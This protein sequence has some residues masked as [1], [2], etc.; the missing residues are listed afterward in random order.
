MALLG[1]AGTC[2]TRRAGPQW[3]PSERNT[4]TRPGSADVG[5]T[6]RHVKRARILTEHEIRHLTRVHAWIG[7]LLAS[8]GVVPAN[9]VV[10][11]PRRPRA[12]PKGSAP[13]RPLKEG[14]LIGP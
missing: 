7:A 9:A 11:A 14:A 4:W 8:N 2:G 13:S 3:M 1:A 5:R 10:P 6:V 12:K